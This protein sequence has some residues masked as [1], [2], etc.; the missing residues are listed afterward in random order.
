[1]KLMT[2][3]REGFTET[4]FLCMANDKLRDVSIKFSEYLKNNTDD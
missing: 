4:L 3:V 1:M 2:S